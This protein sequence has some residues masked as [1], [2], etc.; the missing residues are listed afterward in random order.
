MTETPPAPGVMQPVAPGVRRILAPNPSPMTYWGTHTYVLGEG[1]VALVDPGPMIPVHAEAILAGLAPGERITQILVTHAHLDHSPLARVLSDRTGAPIYAY[2]DAK[3]GRSAVME[4]LA[5]QE[6]TAGGEGVDWDFALDIC[7]ADGE[8]LMTGG[9]LEVEALYTPGHMANH[10][11]FAIGD[12]VLTGDLVMGWAS[13]LIS[14][15]DGDLTAFLASCNRLAA[16][17]DQLYLP[18]HG[19]PVTNP[20]ARLT[21]LVAHRKEREAAILDALQA[22]PA[23]LRNITR[24]VYTDTDPALL[25]AAE[26]NVFAHL[27]DLVGKSMVWALPRLAVDAKFSLA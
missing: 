14:P 24:I 21:W 7:L 13:T 6:L 9:G 17:D 12:I 20:A 2:G 10:L 15:P 3:T 4:E 1:D 8:R 19:A 27:I 25:P 16:R 26:R 11:S 23:D 5:A 18:A 22:G